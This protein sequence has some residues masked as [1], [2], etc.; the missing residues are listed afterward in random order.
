MMLYDERRSFQA[1]IEPTQEPQFS[2][3]FN[4]VYTKGIAQPERTGSQDRLKGYMYA[5][6]EGNNLRVFLDQFAPLQSW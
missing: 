2:V 4:A 1:S 6:R 5:K 3:I